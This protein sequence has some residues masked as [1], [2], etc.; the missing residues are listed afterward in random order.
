MIISTP[1][2]SA[3]PVSPGS[4]LVDG[5]RKY[6]VGRIIAQGGMGILHEAYDTN[7]RRTVAMK[8]LLPDQI[9]NPEELLRFVE[10]AQIT[11]QLEHPNIVPIHEVG[12]DS[13]SRVYYTMKYV[14]GCTLTDVLLGLRRGDMQTVKAYPLS[15]LLNIFQKVC[16]AVAFAHAR[17]VIHRDLKPDNIMLAD[18]G[19]VLLVDWGLAKPFGTREP[20]AS[21][22]STPDPEVVER[23]VI[24]SLRSEE[25]GSGLQT[26]SGHIMGTPGFMAPEQARVQTDCL[27]PHSDIYSLGAV[28]Y[29]ILTLSPPLRP[30]QYKTGRE[31]IEAIHANQITPPI[32]CHHHTEDEQQIP[33]PHCPDG[34]IPEPLSR[35][36]MRALSTDIHSRYQ[37]VPE[38]QQS[39]EAYQNGTAWNLITDDD[40]SK[41]E[42]LQHWESIGGHSEL[43]D[44]ALRMHSGEPQILRFKQD[45]PGDVRLEYQAHIRS[46]YLNNLGCFIAAINAGNRKAI[47]YSGYEFCFGAY[48]NSLNLLSR[49]DQK[50]W[51]ENASPLARHTVYNVIAERSGNHLSLTVNGKQ[52][53]AVD[54]PDPLSGANRTAVGLYSWLSDVYYTRVRIYSRGTPWHADVLDIAERQLQKEHYQVAE[55]L[56]QDILD[57][58][59]DR[60]RRERALL[61]LERT[62]HR[63]ELND[64]LREWRNTLHAAWPKA[65]FDLSLVDENLSLEIPDCGIEDLT[66]LA[67]MPISSLYCQN[68]RIESL[69]PLRGMPLEVLN[70]NDNPISDLSPLHG[71]KLSALF[72][73]NCRVQSLEPLRGLPLTQLN[74]GGCRHIDTLAPL[75]GMRLGFLI[76][77][78]NRINSL[79]PL[80]GMP[81]TGLFC[82]N[83]E[84]SDLSPLHSMPLKML[85]CSGNRIASLEPLHGMQLSWLHCADNRIESLEPLRGMPI[86]MLSCHV[87]RITSLMPLADAN[88]GTLTCGGNLLIDIAPLD[89]NPPADFAFDCPTIP[90]E[91][92]HRIRNRWQDNPD[93]AHH[94]NHLDVVIALREKRDHDLMAL[95]HAFNGAHYLFIPIFMTWKNARDFCHELGGE[96]LTIASDEE[97]RFVT[98]LFP[99][100]CWFWLGLIRDED[101]LGWVDGSPYEYDNF[102]DNLQRN[103]PG[104][105]IFNGSWCSEDNPEAK[106]CFLVKWKNG[107]HTL[108]K[109]RE[110]NR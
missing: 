53:F 36:T 98:S 12:L 67:G 100:G 108:G 88:P 17:R 16:D 29:S 60:M 57:S 47:P 110:M 64:K 80:R 20:N 91:E 52:I 39:I 7:C 43:Y 84:I 9:T 31:L 72:C 23:D 44:G 107:C 71:M 59:P 81:L 41:P 69:D 30:S 6:R 34:L 89:R 61:G 99:N 35:I 77:W 90:L 87:N 73:E 8:V 50:I 1:D 103:K 92:L 102:S 10:E 3:E 105:K 45:I 32:H 15:R 5:N 82:G 18:Y 42:C 24:R 70:C 85:H 62:R 33:F 58:Q 11:A 65:C 19:E 55:T 25:I 56:Y 75:R 79:E 106:N 14:R 96:L 49:A 93:L 63:R 48:D 109:K 28:L 46:V 37:T 97:N 21:R 101:G 95:T 76:C 78:G 104:P 4:L 83:N 13:D 66:P 26:M 40:F 2:Y 94:V 22:H 86:N 38:L 74:C 51:S 68:N 27:S 54:D